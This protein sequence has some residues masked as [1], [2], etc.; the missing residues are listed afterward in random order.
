MNQLETTVG[1]VTLPPAVVGAVNLNNGVFPRIAVS[2]KLNWALATPG[3]EGS[4]SIVDLGRQSINQISSISCT[5]GTST[6]PA[7]V[8]ANTTTTVGLQVG[9]PVLVSGVSPS[10][11]NGIFSVT[12]VS[13]T[14]FQYNSQAPCPTS[15]TSGSGGIASYSFPVATLATN[16]NVSGVSINDETQKA[17]LVDPTPTVPAFVFNIL[18]Q[19]SVA[20]PQS[21]LPSSNNNIATAM[22]PLMNIGLIVNQGV[23][24]GTNGE[25]SL[26][27]P[28]TPKLLSSFPAGITPVVDAAIDPA[29]SMAVIVSQGDN[30]VKVFSVGAL[31]AAP[32]IVQTSFTPVGGTSSSHVT[33]NSTLGSA[34]TPQNQT[35]TLVGNFTAG[36][37]PRLDGNPSVFSGISVSNNRVLTATLSG[38]FLASNGP[39]LYALDVVDSPTS[40]SVFSNVAQL[41]VI[42]AVS[43]V[44]SG[45]SNPAPQGVAID[46]THNVAVVTEPGC[47]PVGAGGVAMVSLSPSTGFPVGTGFGANPQL[48][49]GNNPQ[50]VAVYPQAG[51]A[52]VAASGSNSVSI[53]DVLNDDVATAFTT[54]PIPTGVAVNL[55]T[56]NAVVTARGASLVDVFPVST[57]SQTPTTIGVQQGPT[58]VAIDPKSQTAVVAN[59]NSNT[60]SIV[61]LSTNT[62]TQTSNPIVVPQGVAFDPIFDNFLI[63]SSASNQVIILN[64]S[65]VS[66]PALR[67]GIDPSSIAYNAVSG[68]LV[69]ANSLSGT[70]TM[71]DFLDQTVRA[72]FS[73]KSSSQFAVAIQPQ[74]NLAVIADTADNQLLLVPLPN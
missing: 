51:L 57:S 34:A 14:A 9:E 74:T 20:I 30:S 42:Q 24:K 17:L 16:L 27:D 35:V 4:L 70:V 28:V 23:G 44:T 25:I 18:D 13:N 2:P 38:S 1:A 52:V 40:P 72:V 55:G 50:G 5:P 7:V 67:V 19:S 21:Q 22:D 37:T 33:L 68:T 8:A 43:L 61:N 31:R 15:A 71:V 36:S 3:G 73:L 65:N 46:A 56:G 47:N 59:T 12:A 41:Q 26:I 66:A 6:T 62:T 10:T 69:T 48:A 49:V 11:F 58:G 39:R 60:A 45:C 53:V 54:D 32:Q 63:T 29:T 64:P